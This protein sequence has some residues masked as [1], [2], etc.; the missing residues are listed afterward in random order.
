MK[1]L[2]PVIISSFIG[3]SLFGATM[4]YA[5]VIKVNLKINESIA[6]NFHDVRDDVLKQGDRDIYAI[7]TKN[8][9]GFFDWLSHSDWHPV[10]LRQILDA[11]EGKTRLP[12][13]AILL[14]FDDGT[15]S[16]YTHVYP[17]LKQY[18]LPAVFA[19]VTSWTEGKN[20]G[21]EK[22]YGNGNFMTWAQMREMQ[23]SGLVEF[24]S[25]SDALHQGILANPQDNE[26]P[27]AISRQY[28]KALNRYETDSEFAQRIGDDLKNSKNTLERQL[29]IKVNTIIWPY[30][31]VTPEVEGI[32]RHV[33]LPLS[34]SL[35]HSGINNIYDGTLKRLLITNNPTPEKIRQELI[36][37]V[38]FPTEFR[39]EVSHSIGLNLSNLST[40]NRSEEE[41]RLGLL[42][43][44]IKALAVQ[45]VYVDAVDYEQNQ[46]KA[47]FPNHYIAVKK[48]IL[49]RFIW[50]VKTRIE[51]NVFINF[52]FALQDQPELFQGLIV[53]A[54]KNNSSVSGL[55]FDFSNQ[56]EKL[57]DNPKNS[58]LQKQLIKDLKTVSYLKN[59]A[60]D[61][62]NVSDLFKVIVHHKIKFN[63]KMQLDLILNQMLKSVD[64]VHLSLSVLLPK[65]EQ[66]AFLKQLINLDVGVKQRL[67]ISFDLKKLKQTQDLKQ[68]QK[69]MLLLQQAG[70]PNIGINDYG[71]KNSQDVHNYL[72]IPLSSND[73]PLTY[74]N[75]FNFEPFTEKKNELD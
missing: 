18:K 32:A 71:L 47:Y 2:L 45:S 61:Y 11:R 28:L 42:L 23:Q 59:I 19:I 67:V 10:T 39:T 3:S 75:P 70:I 8:L 12:E 4:S 56:F 53:D 14:N 60:D 66:Q 37:L 29:G 25:H 46:W 73:S 16:G 57:W 13:K 34:F 17:L 52:P 51:S 72:Y 26:E 24:A 35:G 5:E 43:E 31:A 30:G 41:Q 44:R 68:I 64:V 33:G 6:L 63:E 9:A 22:A 58:Q 40:L 54:M 55:Q 62:S 1:Q 15:L 36:S 65:R 74:R 48:D 7:N 20:D 69:L 21:G 38:K 50:Q 49:N 27:A